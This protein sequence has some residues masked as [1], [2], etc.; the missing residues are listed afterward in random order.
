MIFASIS[1]LDTSG[2]Q[3]R[4]QCGEWTDT[5]GWLHIVSDVAIFGA[6]FAIPVLLAYFVA[7]RPDVPFPRVFWLFAAFILFCGLGHLVEAT[8]FWHPWYRLSGLVKVCTAVVS[9]ATVLA[10][11]PAI[12]RAL[13]L[14]GLARLNS[15]LHEEVAE[16]RRTEDELARK[17]A[18]LERANEELERFRRLSVGREQRMIDLKKEVNELLQALGKPPAYNLKF[19]DDSTTEIVGMRMARKASR[20]K[21]S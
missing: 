4:W 6:Y 14:P 17:V 7:K 2:F 8:L 18:A 16:R 13:S 3:P 1:L 15:D 5:H 21:E 10:L 11:V 12:P 20:E 19:M 9:W